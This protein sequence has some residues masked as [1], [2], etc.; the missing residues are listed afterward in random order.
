MNLTT[1]RAIFV[2]NA[3]SRAILFPLD[4]R[5]IDF[6]QFS[7]ERPQTCSFGS[8][9]KPPSS[10]GDV[11][12][13]LTLCQ[14]DG[15]RGV[16][17]DSQADYDVQVLSKTQPV[18]HVLSHGQVTGRPQRPAITY[19]RDL[20]AWLQSPP[21]PLSLFAHESDDEEAPRQQHSTTSSASQQAWLR[22][23]QTP[24]ALRH[25]RNTAHEARS[26]LLDG[27]RNKDLP[28]IGGVYE[29]VELRS[30]PPNIYHIDNRFFQLSACIL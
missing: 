15:L 20:Q 23:F 14:A 21:P 16:R 7:S 6:R 26:T 13:A 28:P 12:R 29:F 17:C 8:A 2:R 27:V 4:A 9:H 30:W 10:L 22:L 1:H 19:Q 3:Y 11:A 18:P 5:P 25:Y 24:S